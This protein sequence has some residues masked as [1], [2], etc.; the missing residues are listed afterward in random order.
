M[1]V[2]DIMLVQCTMYTTQEKTQKRK[3]QLQLQDHKT[4]FCVPLE[5]LVIFLHSFAV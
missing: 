3:N 2:A 4:V 5:V 1:P